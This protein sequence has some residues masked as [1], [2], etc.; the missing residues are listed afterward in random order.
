[1][2][3]LATQQQT[4]LD[5]LFAWPPQA[6][7]QRL[8]TQA[9]GVGANP[10][11]GLMAY[12]SNGHALA[13]RVLQEAYPVLSQMLGAE[14]FAHLARALWHDHPPQRGDIAL[15]GEQL[16][17]FVRHSE[18]L[19]DEPYLADVAHAE[20]AL[21]ICARAMDQD[22]VLSTLALLTTEDAQ[23][24]TLIVA[25]GLVAF[26]SLWP[27]VS[28]VLAHIYGVPSFAEV[29]EQLR[30]RTSQDA[31]IWRQGF[32]PKLRQ[33]MPGECALLTSLA[34][35]ASLESALD[36][37]PSLDFP[38]W[39]PMAVQTGLVLGVQQIASDTAQYT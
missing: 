15:W 38:Q 33:A 18:Q 4:L 10:N 20:W 7:E 9:T 25:P 5:A 21:H 12:Q 36:Q 13:E 2:S 11:R 28:M 26:N 19:R 17:D 27:V 8:K 1:M 14:S 24:L 35:G 22:A 32:Q 30:S 34:S 23:S 31:V 39:L 3:D 29:G 37:A 16:V 6:A